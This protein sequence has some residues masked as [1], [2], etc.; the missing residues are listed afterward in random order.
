METLKQ[1]AINLISNMPNTVGIDDMIYQLYVID[2]IRKGEEAVAR[3]ETISSE[4]LKKE[5]ELW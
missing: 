3:G 2:K 4:D 5:I 1:S